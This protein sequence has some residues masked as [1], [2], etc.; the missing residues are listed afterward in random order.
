MAQDIL[1]RL[2][3]VIG[4]DPKQFVSGIQRAQ[5]ANLK[6]QKN[7]QGLA[8]AATAAFAGIQVGRFAGDLIDLNA[9][10][11]GVENAFNALDRPGL[12][13]KLRAATKGTVSDLQLMSQTVK[14]DNFQIPVEKMGVAFEFVRRRAAATGE[15][16]N[17][18]L[19]SL[20]E[21]IGKKS[22]ARL[23]N[24]GFSLERIREAVKETGSFADGTFKLISEELA[25]MPEDA[26]EAASKIET[27]KTVWE[28]FKGSLSQSK[29]VDSGA[30]ILGNFITN[31]ENALIALDNLDKAKIT[32][33]EKLGP[34][35]F[36]A[37]ARE[38]GRIRASEQA[39]DALRSRFG[40]F[41][42]SDENGTILGGVTVEA[43]RL[44]DTINSIQARLKEINL[45]KG[46]ATGS[47]LASLNREAVT[48]E[49]RLEKLKNL[50]IGA[51]QGGAILS[52]LKGR[53]FD[54]RNSSSTGSIGFLNGE[55]PDKIEKIALKPLPE[56]NKQ[57]TETIDLTAL[58]ANGFTGMFHAIINHGNDAR[59]VLGSFIGILG[60][61]AGALIPGAG[62]LGFAI[63]SQ[64]GGSIGSAVTRG[65][66]IRHSGAITSRNRR[67]SG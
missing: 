47:V 25:K 34:G 32:T 52:K 61:V 65:G 42:K 4:A 49:N 31:T 1:S 19:V 50:G 67:F 18:L 40:G 9:R 38:G 39:Q 27:L 54:I 6:F 30:G 59:N 17:D 60:G 51:G 58:A 29:A 24:L 23:D 53:G 13:A 26:D 48:L 46:D 63:G 36:A 3:V 8:K 28:N 14:A 5:A 37:L 12:L 20:V 57:I 16:V 45:E 35:F 43:S 7:I 22:T 44:F 62:P 15:E 11:K 21:G 55:L 41:K 10:V 33:L 64:I 56:L 2:K 66:D